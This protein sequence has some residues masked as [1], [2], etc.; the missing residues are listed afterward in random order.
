MSTTTI[1]PLVTPYRQLVADL[2]A[3]HC[4]LPTYGFL[5]DDVAHLPCLVVGR[6]SMRESNIAAVMRMSLDVTLLGRRIADEDAQRELDVYLD[7]LFAVLGGTRGV[8]VNDADHIACRII[9]PA[10]VAVAGETYPAYIATVT[11]DALSC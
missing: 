2:L 7:E 3:E 9:V 5:P 11:M 10:Q 4:T 6:V 1:T 8:K